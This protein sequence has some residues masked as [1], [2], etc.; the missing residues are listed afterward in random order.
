MHVVEQSDVVRTSHA[1]DEDAILSQQPRQ[2]PEPGPPRPDREVREQ[3]VHEHDRVS[4]VV[5]DLGRVGGRAESM[6]AEG[7]TT[8]STAS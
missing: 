6:D 8:K 4:S 2:A 1:E 3:G 5:L 7:R